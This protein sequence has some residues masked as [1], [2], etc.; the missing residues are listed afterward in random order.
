[1]RVAVIISGLIDRICAETIKHNI[2]NP[3][4]ADT[5]VV[6]ADDTI[7]ESELVEIWNPKSYYYGT[8]PATIGPNV[9]SLNRFHR[10]PETN[11]E[12]IVK[13]Y[14]G[15]HQANQLRKDSNEVYDIVVRCRADLFIKEKLE[16]KNTGDIYI[17]IGFDNR[18]GYNDTFAYGNVEVMDWYSELYNRLFIYANNNFIIHPE[19]FLKTHLNHTQYGIIRWHYPTELRGMKLNELEYRQK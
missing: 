19:S 16:I 11:T 8:F 13:M 17:P 2:I 7:T 5:F 10:Y 1:M 12:S 3:Y 18:N 15:I 4:S 6:S 14:W 9:T